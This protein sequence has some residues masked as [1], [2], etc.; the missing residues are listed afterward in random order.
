MYGFCFMGSVFRWFIV[1]SNTKTKYLHF[2]SFKEVLIF[3]QQPPT[4]C[5]H[6]LLTHLPSVSL[7]IF[8]VYLEPTCSFSQRIL[9]LLQLYL[10]SNSK[11]LCGNNIFIY[12]P[13]QTGCM[14]VCVCVCVCARVRVYA[15]MC[16]VVSNSL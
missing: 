2:Y 6:L 11:S 7:A 8:S 9:L 15:S 1:Y 12:L 13:I 10:Y 5:P 3:K 16:S 4:T 14:C